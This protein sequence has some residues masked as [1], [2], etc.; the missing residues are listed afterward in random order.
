MIRIS[1]MTRLYILL[2]LLIFSIGCVKERNTPEE[3]TNEG[4]IY[5]RVI[6]PNTGEGIDGAIIKC[7]LMDSNRLNTTKSSENGEYSFDSL[8]PGTY[9]LTVY[10]IVEKFYEHN[11]NDFVQLK[12]GATHYD[13][14]LG[15]KGNHFK[16]TGVELNGEGDSITVE[17]DSIVN[18]TFN[19]SVW[20]YTK[21]PKNRVYIPFGIDNEP[22]DSLCCDEPGTFPGKRGSGMIKLVAPSTKGVYGVYASFAAVLNEDAA[23]YNYEYH[24]IEWYDQRIPIGIL[25]VI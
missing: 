12:N 20:S 18:L 8:K 11:S 9:K 1:R 4:K 5:G 15:S 3:G 19:Y 17:S 16:V 14:E 7:L 24:A 2:L 6:D 10:R 23:F 22:Q 21:S 25:N 13:L